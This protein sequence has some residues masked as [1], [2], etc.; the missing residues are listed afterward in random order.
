MTALTEADTCRKYVLHKLYAS[1]WDDDQTVERKT[2]TNG[3]AHTVRGR[4]RTVKYLNE[5]RAQIGAFKQLQE[6]APKQPGA[7]VPFILFRAFVWE[8]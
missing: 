6:Q 1:G 4:S 7:G 5:L 8:V 2:F 3:R